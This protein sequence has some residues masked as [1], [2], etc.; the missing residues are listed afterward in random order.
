MQLIWRCA[1]PERQAL[2]LEM[3]VFVFKESYENKQNHGQ[4]GGGSC[5]WVDLVVPVHRAIGGVPII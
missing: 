5:Y 1:K 4:A 3:F 2:C